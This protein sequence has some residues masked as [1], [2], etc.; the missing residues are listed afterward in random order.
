MSIFSLCF[1]QSDD[2]C[3]IVFGF[4][5]IVAYA[6]W[7]KI[8][9]VSILS[10]ISRITSVS[11]VQLSIVSAILCIS[12]SSHKVYGAILSSKVIAYSYTGSINTFSSYKGS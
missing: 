3:L 1:T 5:S 8:T 12:F 11:L 6:E 7:L 10:S 9:F 4:S 2:F